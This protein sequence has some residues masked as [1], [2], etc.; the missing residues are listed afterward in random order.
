MGSGRL[1]LLLFNPSLDSWMES[2]KTFFASVLLSTLVYN[3]L[4]LANDARI[5]I[6]LVKC[7]WWVNRLT[8][9]KKN[10]FSFQLL[11]LGFRTW[12]SDISLLLNNFPVFSWGCC[13]WVSEKFSL[14]RCQ[15]VRKEVNRLVCFKQFNME[16]RNIFCQQ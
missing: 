12:S 1:H 13:W 11:S 14:L 6:D 7:F 8:K 3:P 5:Q 9:L 16:K 2:I 10:P 4:F 15:K